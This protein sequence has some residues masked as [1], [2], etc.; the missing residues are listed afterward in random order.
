M[1]LMEERL[2]P[3]QHCLAQSLAQ[4]AARRTAEYIGHAPIWR[5]VEMRFARA[6]LSSAPGQIRAPLL[7]LPGK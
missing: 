1:A 4:L 5:I 2:V 7:V 3:R 6:L